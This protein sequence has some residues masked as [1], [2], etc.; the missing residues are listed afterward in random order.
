MNAQRS[1]GTHSSRGL[2]DNVLNASKDVDKRGIDFAPACGSEPW[3]DGVHTAVVGSDRT[4][5][6]FVASSRG[7]DES[8]DGCC[9][10]ENTI[11]FL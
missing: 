3:G 4:S 1:Q 8:S 5:R 7:E 11:V 6:V 9:V 10:G 2:G